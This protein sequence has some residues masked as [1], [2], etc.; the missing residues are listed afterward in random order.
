MSKIT[1][2]LFSVIFSLLLVFNTVRGTVFADEN[3]AVETAESTTTTETIIQTN[4]GAQTSLPEA[5]VKMEKESAEETIT[6]VESIE[7]VEIV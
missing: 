7:N 4:D 5:E 6:K 3:E 2:K 1:R